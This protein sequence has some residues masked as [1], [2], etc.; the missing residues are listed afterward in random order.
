MNGAKL[1]NRCATVQAAVNPG[2]V[3]LVFSLELV[4]ASCAAAAGQ[5]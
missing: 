1:T 4:L 3:L 2:A 5:Y